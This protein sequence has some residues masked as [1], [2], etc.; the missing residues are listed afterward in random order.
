MAPKVIPARL[1]PN[2][3]DADAEQDPLDEHDDT[4][5]VT[6][7]EPRRSQHGPCLCILCFKGST[8]SR[9]REREG[10][11]CSSPEF[12]RQCDGSL[13]THAQY[14]SRIRISWYMTTPSVRTWIRV[15]KAVKNLPSC[16]NVPTYNNAVR[17][18]HNVDAAHIHSPVPVP[19]VLDVVG[20]TANAGK[21][22][23]WKEDEEVSRK[24]RHLAT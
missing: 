4:G 22:V 24:V 3:S 21:D 14:P 5:K 6:Q 19:R 9:D 18:S 12:A 1:F 11:L 16:H 13:E 23:E 2:H 17:S 7:Y 15:R 8:T 10:G 20:D